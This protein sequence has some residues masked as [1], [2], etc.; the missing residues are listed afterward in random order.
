MTKYFT[1][2]PPEQ[3]DG[4]KRLILLPANIADAR[5]KFFKVGKALTI[6]LIESTDHAHLLTILISAPTSNIVT[7]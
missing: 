5:V 3:I 4:F 1:V 7:Q 6:F 2:E